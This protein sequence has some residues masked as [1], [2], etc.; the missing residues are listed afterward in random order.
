MFT[1]PIL[2]LLCLCLCL[3]FLTSP[4]HVTAVWSPHPFT[5]HGWQLQ[6]IGDLDT[7]VNA[8]VYIID[9]FTANSTIIQ[10]LHNSSRIVACYF[11]AGV[12]QA[13]VPSTTHTAS[14]EHAH[15]YMLT[16]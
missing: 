6:L 16:D 1:T 7:A 4:T 3:T 2:P 15:T 14:D 13:Y 5:T 9:L 11:A 10:T 8:P 12:Y